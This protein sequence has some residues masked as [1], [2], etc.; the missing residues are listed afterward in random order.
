MRTSRILLIASLLAIALMV[1][2]A[3]AAQVEPQKKPTNTVFKKVGNSGSMKIYP[4]GLQNPFIMVKQEKIVEQFVNNSKVQ[5]H[6]VNTAGGRWSNVEEAIGPDGTNVSAYNITYTRPFRVNGT[7]G[8]Y[9]F[10]VS[11]YPNATAQTAQVNISVAGNLTG[12]IGYAVDIDDWILA[13]PSNHLNMTIDT[14]SKGGSLHNNHKQRLALSE[15]DPNLPV[16][17][18]GIAVAVDSMFSSKNN[19]LDLLFSFPA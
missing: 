19:H 1:A 14:E 7:E 8:L 15:S 2:G 11:F 12:A 6:S 3:A 16:I 17:L 13:D 18:N 5:D 4:N 9:T 10:L